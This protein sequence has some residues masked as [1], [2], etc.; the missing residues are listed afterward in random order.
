M[1]D[2][3]IGSIEA[4]VCFR[5]DPF[6]AKSDLVDGAIGELSGF[7]HT[8]GIYAQGVSV[9]TAV[10][11]PGWQHRLVVLDTPGSKP[12]RGLCPERHD[13][14]ASKLAAGREKDLEFAAALLREHI[15][16]PGTLRERVTALPL[17]ES[18]R[19]RVMTWISARV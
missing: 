9:E 15:V 10:L 12:G 18:S 4:D 7:H 6:N 11:A 16:D 3:A 19:R 17:A 13:L 14:V 1:P 2:E 8:F 5:D